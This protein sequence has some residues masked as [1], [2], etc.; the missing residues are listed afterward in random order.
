MSRNLKSKKTV[1]DIASPAEERGERMETAKT[2]ARGGKSTGSVPGATPSPPQ[3]DADGSPTT[4]DPSLSPEEQ[5]RRAVAH[6]VAQLGEDADLGELVNVCREQCGI[7]MS[8][9]EVANILTSDRSSQ[10]PHA[11][12][13]TD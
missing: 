2:I 13:N 7:E 11:S 4:P 9:E 8:E 3:P 10:N 1:P 12:A 6:A 5:N